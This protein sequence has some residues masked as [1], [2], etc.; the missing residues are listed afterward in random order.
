MWRVRA[1][2]GKNEDFIIAFGIS[3]RKEAEAE[4][5]DCMKEEPTNVF[6]GN[7]RTY[8]VER[9]GTPENRLARAAVARAG[10]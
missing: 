7:P 6:T 10:K 3:T 2:S 8:T 5:A 9:G 4:A 1:M